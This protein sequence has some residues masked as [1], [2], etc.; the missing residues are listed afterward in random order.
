MD[1]DAVQQRAGDSAAVALDGAVFA[2]AR[3]IGDAG[4]EIAAGTGVHGGDEHEFRG[5]SE[6]LGG[7]G[8][9]DDAILQGLAQHFQH[10]ALELRQLIQKQHAAMRQGY[11]AGT[12]EGSTPNQGDI[13]DGVMRAAIGAGGEDA[14]VK[15]FGV[16]RHGVDLGGLQG[17]VQREFR[18]DGGHT[19]GQHGLTRA[20][21]AQ[22]QQVVASGGGDLQGALDLKLPLHVV[23]IH[24]KG[25]QG[26]KDL[27]AVHLSGRNLR[28][29]AQKE[30]R[31]LQRSDR[32]HL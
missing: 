15:I 3:V 1:V 24:G 9:G 18:Q 11:L 30:G 20:G 21:R 12:G 17:F 31:L 13:A 16:S 22:H 32:D 19:P 14:V 2:G 23:H 5:K 10:A 6:A 28:L 27:L 8:D 25:V 7:A 29:S 4:A 26:G